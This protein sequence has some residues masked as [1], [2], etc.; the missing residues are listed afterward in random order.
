MCGA[1]RSWFL[2]SGRRWVRSPR[3]SSAGHPSGSRWWACGCAVFTNLTRAHRDY[4]RTM[5]AYFEA[6]A[7]LF[8]PGLSRAG[9]IDVDTAQGR[10]M[11]DRAIVPVVTVGVQPGAEVRAEDVRVSAE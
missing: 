11:A 3:R 9:V 2:R 5:E 6:K 10:R 7:R 4:H 8:T 1:V